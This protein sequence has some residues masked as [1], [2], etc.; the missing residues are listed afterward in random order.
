MLRVILVAG[1]FFSTLPLMIALQWTLAA[2]N[3]RYWG[4]CSVGYYRLLTRALRI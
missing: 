4:P 3:S 2:L 1:F